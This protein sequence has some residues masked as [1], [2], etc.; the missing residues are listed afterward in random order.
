MI[1]FQTNHFSF[2]K[3]FPSGKHTLEQ[4]GRMLFVSKSLHKTNDNEVNEYFQQR[5]NQQVWNE[6]DVSEIQG[7]SPV[8]QVPSNTVSKVVGPKG[9]KLESNGCSL[10]IPPNALSEEIKV[11]ITPYANSKMDIAPHIKC[12][13][14]GLKFH[15]NVTITLPIYKHENNIQ[16][17]AVKYCNEGS[18][19]RTLTKSPSYTDAN[20]CFQTNHFT[21]FG[22]DLQD[23]SDSQSL[24]KEKI[25]KFAVRRSASHHLN[26]ILLTCFFADNLEI[27]RESDEFGHLLSVHHKEFDMRNEDDPVKMTITCDN[28]QP[29]SKEDRIYTRRLALLHYMITGSDERRT[30]FNVRSNALHTMFEGGFYI[31][32][33]EPTNARMTDRVDQ[34]LLQISRQIPNNMWNEFART[35]LDID[36]T[37]IGNSMTD[38]HTAEEHRR[39]ILICWNEHD[40]HDAIELQQLINQ[41]WEK[42]RNRQL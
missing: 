23:P 14:P 20:I 21:R 42:A 25:V 16:Q 41:F 34:E 40:G 36:D 33:L 11:T 39:F 31:P 30:D 22:V 26:R 13:P 38:N 17:I 3:A 9:G 1:S 7:K 27:I 2:F 24:E 4:D 18:T 32:E 8:N 10:L 6:D 28:N 5:A 35:R 37:A 19:W 15:K 29:Q 12:G